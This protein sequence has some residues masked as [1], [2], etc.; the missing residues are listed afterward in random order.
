MTESF[1]E[2]IPKNPQNG[3]ILTLS[4]LLYANNKKTSYQ[5]PSD[6]VLQLSENSENIEILKSEIPSES[7]IFS[8]N[9]P[10]S[11]NSKNI[12]WY[13]YYPRN[14]E[15]CYND[16][17]FWDAYRFSRVNATRDENNENIFYLDIDTKKNICLVAGL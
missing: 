15:S 16:N 17:I 8:V 14:E 13:V 10:E 3:D 9:F 1:V 4:A 2:I 11:I 12:L 6:V 5:L 7:N